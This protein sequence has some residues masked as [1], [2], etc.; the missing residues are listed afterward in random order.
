MNDAEHSASADCVN[1]GRPAQ[2][3]IIIGKAV[4]KQLDVGG[5]QIDD[6]VDI[7][8]ETRLALGNRRLG[9]GDHVG[10]VQTIEQ[11]TDELQ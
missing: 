9:S 8:R 11:G 1:G 2:I 10:D 3:E 5:R 7:V 4:A 6:D